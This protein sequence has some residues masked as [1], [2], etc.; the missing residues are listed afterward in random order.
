MEWYAILVV[1][2]GLMLALFTTGMRVAFAFLAVNIIGMVWFLGGQKGLSLLTNS[3]YDSVAFISLTPLPL[4]LM[5]AEILFQS[6][7]VKA[8]L[9]ALDNLVGKVKARLNILLLLS[10]TL[11]GAISG[12]GMGTVALLGRSLLPEMI[13]RGYD[14]K[15]SMGC[16]M[17]T[18]VLDA[19]VPPSTIAVVVGSLAGVSVAK[20]L[21]GGII[22]GIILC[23]MYM[24]Y[25]LI[26]VHLKPSLAPPTV[27]RKVGLSEKIKSGARLAPLGVVV[28]MV[29]GTMQLGV[30]TPSEAAALGI[31]GSLLILPLYRA[32][33]FKSLKNALM[34]TLTTTAMLLL[35]MASAKAFSQILSITGASQGLTEWA[36]SGNFSPM[37]V[38]FMM[39]AVAF[40]LGTFLDATANMMICIPVFLP[41][42]TAL[43]FD[44][45]WFWLVYL[46][47]IVVG[48]ITP[49]YGMY[50][51]T[52]KSV[53]PETPMHEVFIASIPF[54][55]I[56]VALVFLMIFFPSL[57]TWL[58]GLAGG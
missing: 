2:V 16:L 34:P 27:T 53:S 11:F 8:G 44:P 19:L 49:P 50:L 29:L 41:V 10:G 25:I 35:I 23:S 54:C 15:L 31:V 12:V 55:L 5:M 21:I 3:M 26:A 30:A 9:D 52:A 46:V 13:R 48:E 58:P 40:F 57:A 56:A 32:N 18:G 6:G 22:P 28:F 45:V 17:S 42:V 36:V 14:R 39:Q 43:N 7:A 4:Y 20:M 1:I 51:F 33:P 37:T 38:F 47:N 24:A